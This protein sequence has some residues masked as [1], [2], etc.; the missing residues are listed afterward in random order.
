M[1]AMP[2]IDGSHDVARSD[3]RLNDRAVNGD[4]EHAEAALV[5]AGRRRGGSSAGSSSRRDI[6][7]VHESVF[8]HR[9]TSHV[10]PMKCSFAAFTERAVLLTTDTAD[11]DSA[12][13]GRRAFAST[14]HRLRGRRPRLARRRGIVRRSNRRRHIAEPKMGDVTSAIGRNRKP[15]NHGAEAKDDSTA[16]AVRSPSVGRCFPSEHEDVQRRGA[17]PSLRPH[18]RGSRSSE[19]LRQLRRVFAPP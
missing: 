6:H 13:G 4:R 7:Q 16:V 5:P 19:W 15:P 2:V 14:V 8:D 9:T 12:N 18:R 3:G 17:L 1:Q 10:T 11:D